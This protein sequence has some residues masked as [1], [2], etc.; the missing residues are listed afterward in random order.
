[1]FEFDYWVLMGLGVYKI[2]E[3]CVDGGMTAVGGGMSAV[4]S[5]VIFFGGGMTAVGLEGFIC[6]WLK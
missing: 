5:S 6:D 4:G 1:M 3:D 2:V